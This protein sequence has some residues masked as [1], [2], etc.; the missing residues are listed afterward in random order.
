MA[1]GDPSPSVLEHRGDLVDEGRG[2]T[3][4]CDRC[5]ADLV[6]HIGS[7]RLACPFCGNEE[8]ISVPA[9]VEIR[10][11]DL[12]RHLAAQTANHYPAT[13]QP[14]TAALR[15]TDLEIRCDDCGGTVVFQGTLT[16]HRC[17]Y[18][19]NP[20]LRENIHRAADRIPV[21]A[22]LPFTITQAVARQ[23]VV[24]WVA[25]RWFAPN[26]FR[27]VSRLV[28][29]G[30]TVFTAVYFPYWTFDLLTV[31][32]YRGERGN[33]YT[34]TVGTGKNRRRKTRIRWR[35]ASGEFD[36]F[37]DDVLVMAHTG[38]HRPHVREIEPFP[39]ADATPF[40]PE[41]LAG[42]ISRTYDTT[43]K[44]GFDEAFERVTAAIET[45]VR[46]RIGGDHQRVHQ[47]QT[48]TPALSFKHV[49]LPIWILTYP[50]RDRVHHV[51]VNG[52]TGAVA[53]SRPYSPW[54]IAFA[55]LLSLLTFA[56]AALLF[57]GR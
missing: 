40:V 49:L 28:E 20:L 54:K 43:L 19:G 31:N 38:P 21:D 27:S 2:R 3:F 45:D 48:A 22:V 26:R 53:G 37:F 13:D 18:C 8:P 1:A 16:S 46:N 44:T 7:R 29:S 12:R 15:P 11:H 42:M 36:R 23:R 47:I 55:V 17:P 24:A 14:L 35:S 9:D 50:D 57:S 5:G 52:R 41:L 34:V 30:R 39:L 6:Y 33:N 51:V 10:E 32:R 56:L 4:P 25:S